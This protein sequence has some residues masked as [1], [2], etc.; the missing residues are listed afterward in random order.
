M[1]RKSASG[2]EI[3]DCEDLPV[4]PYGAWSKSV[5]DEHPEIAQELH[6]HLQGIGKFVK[7]MDLV[8]FMDTPK[9]WLHSGVKKKRLDISTAQRWMWN[10]DS[11]WIYSELKGQYV[12]GHK[13]EDVVK[14]QNEVFL[15]R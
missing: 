6:A 11:H 15:P 13:R 2:L 5:I 14:Y 10:L 9:M 12:D 4:N 3:D 8:D 1:Q 7:A